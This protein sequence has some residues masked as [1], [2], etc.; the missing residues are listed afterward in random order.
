MVGEVALAASGRRLSSREAK[1]AGLEVVTPRTAGCTGSRAV[2][3]LIRRPSLGWQ[4]H[5]GGRP[6][7]ALA[8]SAEPSALTRLPVGYL[9]AGR[10]T[11]RPDT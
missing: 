10:S 1:V 8:G 9:P 5:R 7:A 4:P 6:G 2:S 3:V 11:V